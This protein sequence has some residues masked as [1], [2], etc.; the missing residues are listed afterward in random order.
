MA[1]LLIDNIEDKVFSEMFMKERLSSEEVE[2][3]CSVCGKI[4]RN[5]ESQVG[6]VY[7]DV[8]RFIENLFSVGD[9]IFRMEKSNGEV[10][11]RGV[12]IIRGVDSERR[13]L[14]VVCVDG[15]CVGDVDDVEVWKV[16][17]SVRR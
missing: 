17:A 5:M 7:V 16:I 4:M 3:L 8:K 15:E 12:W 14:R 2:H 1:W 9:L 11:R 10:K 6:E 13:L